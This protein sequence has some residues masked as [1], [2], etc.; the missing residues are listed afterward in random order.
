MSSS[1]SGM[2]RVPD[3]TTGYSYDVFLRY[4]R[5]QRAWARQLAE[6]LDREGVR[7]W[8]DEWMLQSGADRRVALRRALDE[9]AHIALVLS[10]EFVGEPW[11]KDELYSGFPHAPA[12]QNQRL[13]PLIYE[14]CEL[15][16]PVRDLDAV[17]FVGSDDDAT[18]FEFQARQ[19]L[20]RV[21]PG[22]R[23]PTDVQ[24][25]RLQT[26]P[27][28]SQALMKNDQDLN[29]FRSFIRNLQQFIAQLSSDRSPGSA[30]EN[31]R[32]IAILQ[33]IQRLFQWNTADLQF[34]RGEE[35]FVQGRYPNALAAYDRALNIDPNFAMAWS[36]RG[37][38]LV[39]LKRYREAIDSYNGSLAINPYD[40]V[41]LN[42]LATI[43]GRMKRYK[44]AIANYDKLLDLD[45][46]DA[47]AWHNRGVRL[48]QTERWKQALSSL[49]QAIRNDPDNEQSWLARGYVLQAL[50]RSK[51]AIASFKQ[52][53]E[54][55]PHDAHLWRKVGDLLSQRGNVRGALL[56]Y[57]RSLHLRPDLPETWHNR[58]VLLLELQYY[59]DAAASFDRTFQ[60][61]PDRAQ[62]WHA[63][64]YT[65]ERMELLGDA[66][67]QYEEALKIQPDYYPA[68]YA[69]AAIC[70]L[71][72]KSAAAVAYFNRALQ[73]RPQSFA[74]LYGKTIALRRLKQW[75][76]AVDTCDRM[77]DIDERDAWGWF[78][79]G[80]V[81]GDRGDPQVALE[82][83]DRALDLNLDDA[84]VLNNRAWA[85]CQLKQYEAARED[86]ERATTLNDANANFWHTLGRAQTGCKDKD[87]AIAS[88]T[89]ALELD[90]EFKTA[91]RSLDLLKA[92][93][94]SALPSAQAP[95]VDFAKQAQPEVLPAD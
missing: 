91:Q 14:P 41:V 20:G 31:E 83:F 52:V 51:S 3:S 87:A 25:F 32:Q 34:E 95:V 33:F 23:A 58:G 69:A 5:A 9:S 76:S 18:L 16:A 42:N 63:R 94:S 17:N 56:A 92:V 4:H 36:R 74:C 70:N 10:P 15:P 27:S 13:L 61:D 6:R 81:F 46:D 28:Q 35:E 62:M 21:K 90:P 7:V 67:L 55:R 93:E 2:T 40:E 65:F 22:Y 77:V 71:L 30:E 37:D 53:L 48:A 12:S 24:R 26:Q 79:L 54:I 29:V 44:A 43:L 11:P 84:I 8:F 78:G 47:L 80:M 60:I 50:G 75:Q 68:L 38:A 73:L 64:G 1:L 19:L 57:N 82:C 39:Q 72:G 59:R 49:N 89:R 88:F 85:L 45:P 86:A 66:L